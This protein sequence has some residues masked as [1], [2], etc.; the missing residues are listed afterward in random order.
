MELAHRA[1]R[2]SHGI[3][4]IR[5]ERAG[6]VNTE[7]STVGG[8]VA[9]DHGDRRLVKLC[10]FVA[11]A[12]GCMLAFPLGGR[13]GPVRGT[14]TPLAARV[15]SIL[16]M[17]IGH[18]EYLSQYRR[19]VAFLAATKARWNNGGWRAF[20]REM[21]P[22]KPEVR[23][24][25]KAVSHG[26][27]A[28][29]LRNRLLGALTLGG[30]Y[31]PPA[32]HKW[33]YGTLALRMVLSNYL[34]HQSD[35]LL[36]AGYWR[37]AADYGRAS[38]ILRCQDSVDMGGPA[39]LGFWFGDPRW[40]PVASDNARSLV[41]SSTQSRKL[42]WI[43]IAARRR[44]MSFASLAT[45]PF[46]LLGSQV[47]SLARRHIAPATLI[48]RYARALKARLLASAGRVYELRHALGFYKEV[49]RSLELN[50]HRRSAQSLA[51][52]LA[53][54]PA[55]NLV[56]PKKDPTGAMAVRRWISEVLPP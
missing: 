2:S 9:A 47:E 5:T 37:R 43:Y 28:T 35:E 38:L 12:T 52:T 46:F 29:A 36:S 6:V 45:D 27:D 7:M 13:A 25:V 44:Y 48:A 21:V 17:P 15:Q 50:G 34:T 32:G 26:I 55:A 1:R 51:S 49:V 18:N 23:S 33:R 19:I 56:S 22:M 10:L 30:D 41:L 54:I 42:R 16:G 11:M 20:D 39:L 31:L 40:M 8:P 14:G 3:L 53:V 4:N 24:L